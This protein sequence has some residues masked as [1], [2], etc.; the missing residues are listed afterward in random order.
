MTFSD[1]TLFEPDMPAPPTAAG[2]K[3]TERDV[4]DALARRYSQR[5]GNG[6]R[7]A[8]A[9]HVKSETGFALGARLRIADAIAVDCWTSKGQEIHGHEVKV[10]RSDWLAELRDPEK[11]EAFR[12]YVDRWWLVVPGPVSAIVR[13]D[14]P[15]GWGLMVVDGIGTRTSP[16]TRVVRRA[17]RLTPV[18]MPRPMLAALMRATAKTAERRA[19]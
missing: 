10:S 17:P 4:L 12:P 19:A 9:E 8:Y 5:Y 18:D 7:W 13:D 16:V 6:Y 14:L 15:D 3:V 2:Q 1:G 11:A